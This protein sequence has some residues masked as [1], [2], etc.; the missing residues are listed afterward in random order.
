MINDSGTGA[1]DIVRESRIINSLDARN[2]VQ[3]VYTTAGL[4]HV[5]MCDNGNTATTIWDSYQSPLYP[6]RCVKAE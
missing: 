3:L 5:A 1:I 4:G 6:R 2:D